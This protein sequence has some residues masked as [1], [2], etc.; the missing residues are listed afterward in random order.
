MSFYSFHFISFIT[1]QHQDTQ[2]SINFS[3]R[4]KTLMFLEQKL[5]N[6]E[7][8]CT[9]VLYLAVPAKKYFDNGT[10]LIFYFLR[11]EKIVA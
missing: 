1:T 2:L 7:K 10:T 11:Q 4:N 5:E 8:K 9:G 3:I 6:E